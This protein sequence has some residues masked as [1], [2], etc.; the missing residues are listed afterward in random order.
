[1]LACG[2]TMPKKF[3]DTPARRF[4]KLGT[5]GAKVAGKYTG[6][7]LRQVFASDEDKE[8]VQSQLY[9]EIGEQVMQ[10]LG[11]LKGAAM[12]VGQI[13]SQ[14]QQ[15]L[16]PEFTRQI[17]KLQQ[18]SPPMPYEVIQKQIRTELGFLPEQLFARFDAEPFAAASIG[19]VHRAQTHDGREVILKVQYPGVYQ[20]CRSDL[21][22][23]K[24]LFMLSGL[25]K[26]EKAVM[27]TLF[28]DIEANLMAELDYQKEADNLKEF[29]AFH[30]DDAFVIVPEVIDDYSRERV[31]CL[32]YEPG[33]SL[34]QLR[35]KG[36]SQQQI[37]TAA[38]NLIS[39][40]L[41]ELLYKLRVHC[42]PHPGNFAFRPDGSVIIYDYGAVIDVQDQV[43]DRY[44]E[45]AQ[46]ALNHQFERID[47]LLLE[48]GVRNPAADALPV[49]LYRQWYND[50]I[51]PALEEVRP[52]MVMQRIQPAIK[53]HMMD[54]IALRGAFQPSTATLF[55]NRV[56]GGHFLNLVQ[57][58][59]DVDIKPVLLSHLFEEE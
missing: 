58:D 27:D 41:Q 44:I 46:A 18:Q 20:S 42:D 40:M 12:K 5:M 4:L 51:L 36:Y 15:V 13:A 54:A 30:K 55:I 49:D 52:A 9:S 57:M 2:C 32:A 39:A 19:Q 33:D 8:Q 29:R 34:T 3:A 35:E 48:L 22:H 26:V 45:L 28:A 59:I 16:P 47:D 24:R 17:A 1:M 21:V 37:N 14:L 50:F 25:M 6:S 53:K 10:T 7:K 31:L 56:L 23:L 11:E 43:I 38:V